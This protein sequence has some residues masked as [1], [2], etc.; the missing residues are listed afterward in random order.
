MF[1]GGT[2]QR[3]HA[4]P[5]RFQSGAAIIDG[6][7]KLISTN[8]RKDAWQLYDLKNDPAE[9]TDLSAK[10]LE[11]FAKMR[12]EAMAMVGRWIRASRARITLT[13]RKGTS[14]CS[15]RTKSRWRRCSRSPTRTGCSDRFISI[16]TE[17]FRYIRYRDDQEEL[18]DCS[19]DPHEWHTQAAN[20]AY[21]ATLAEVRR[22]VPPLAQMA[23]ALPRKRGAVEE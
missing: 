1:D 18:Y 12:A 6:D 8:D 19:K 3:T 14:T 9:T 16:R 20:P 2:P 7:F 23:K 4:I 22:A 10:L 17:Q 15:P 21:A 5:F 13:C 11:R